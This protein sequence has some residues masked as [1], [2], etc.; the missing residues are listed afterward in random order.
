MKGIEICLC[1][2]DFRDEKTW[3]QIMFQLNW[4]DSTKAVH[5]EVVKTVDALDCKGY[6]VK[7]K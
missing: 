4:P 7:T 1:R 5:I 6:V 3:K 2:R